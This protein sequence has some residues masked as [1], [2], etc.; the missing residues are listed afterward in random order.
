MMCTYYYDYEY[1]CETWE[2]CSTA[3]C[4][5]VEEVKGVECGVEN[6]SDR[7]C[8]YFVPCY[9]ENCTVN[10]P[11]IKGVQCGNYDNDNLCTYWEPCYDEGCSEII[12]EEILAVKCDEYDSTEKCLKWQQ[13]STDDCTDESG[14]SD[15]EDFEWIC[16]TYND[17]CTDWKSCDDP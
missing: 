4:T 3:N 5:V 6:V 12:N 13:C 8:L 16:T 17:Y 9:T 11:G 14:D 7:E 2:S 10:D 1:G 15:V